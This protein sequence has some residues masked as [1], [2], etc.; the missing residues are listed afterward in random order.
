MQ[1]K[2]CHTR[3]EESS[4]HNMEDSSTNR[5][6][7]RSPSCKVQKTGKLLNER[8]MKGNCDVAPLFSFSRMYYLCPKRNVKK[9]YKALVCALI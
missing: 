6:A 1:M 9:I 4:G 7:I 5:Y 8:K 3:Y 2:L